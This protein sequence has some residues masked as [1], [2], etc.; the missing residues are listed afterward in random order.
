MNFANLNDV[1]FEYLC[2]DIMSKKLGV[3]L[4]RFAQGR[5]GGV[6]LTD[7][8]SEK[9]IVVQVKHYI[10]TDFSGLLSSIKK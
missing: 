2:K 3:E 9:N 5:D 7:S 6:D 8:L 10:K 1:E 4:R